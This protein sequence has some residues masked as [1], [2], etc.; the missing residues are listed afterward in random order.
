MRNDDIFYGNEIC[1]ATYGFL[2][3][4]QDQ[5]IDYKLFEITSSVPFGIKHQREENYSRLLTTYCD[6]SIGLDRAAE[7]WG[8]QQEKK[9]FPSSKD[10][11]DYIRVQSNAKNCLVGP[12]DM[13]HLGYLIFPNLY[14]NMDHY[15]AVYQKDG[16]MFCT[17]SEGFPAREISSA[18]L[19]MW[20]HS[21]ELPEAKGYIA[22]RT[23]EKIVDCPRKIREENAIKN[24]GKWILSNLLESQGGTAVR[25][26]YYWLQENAIKRW[27]LSFLYDIS[28]LMQRKL[29]Q[30]DWI[31]HIEPFVGANSDCVY[32]IQ[33]IVDGQIDLLREIFK[34][35]HKEN[36]TDKAYFWA[37]AAS[38]EQLTTEI[39]LIVHS[40]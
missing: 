2:N 28:Y 7:L 9:L 17:D 12:I 3:V 37:L 13:G 40:L 25:Q 8:Y 1:C 38:E 20:L 4:T 11:V 18:E 39:G 22:V 21:E 15:I 6:P 35:L 32:V 16:R 31:G 30:K 26:C 29:L 33:K 5:D 10:A 36:R 27:K 19:E 23:F 14:T 24:C 34:L